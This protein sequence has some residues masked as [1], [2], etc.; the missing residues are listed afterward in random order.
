MSKIQFLPCPVLDALCF[1]EKSRFGNPDIPSH[2]KVAQLAE[3]K[4][5]NAQLSPEFPNDHLSMS[6]L[7]LIVTTAADTPPET[8]T[9]DDLIELFRHPEE[10][11]RTVKSRIPGGFLSTFVYPLLD[12]LVDGHAAIYV[13]KLEEL[14]GIG[15]DV[16][17]RERILPLVEEEIQRN[18]ARM[19]GFDTE[20]LFAHIA[21]LRG[22]SEIPASKI[23]VSLFS[24]P[25]AFSLYGGAFLTCFD[26][27]DQFSLAAHELMHGFA[28]EELTALYLQYTDSD[29]YLQRM[30]NHLIRDQ[31]SG[32]EEEFVVAAQHYL[33]LLSGRYDRRELMREV[34]NFYGGCCPTA[35]VVFD[36]LSREKEVP[37]DYKTWL[38]AQITGG[39]LRRSAL[40]NTPKN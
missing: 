6:A 40:R 14:R 15:F 19:E 10:L 18:R 29:P 8:W 5:F 20:A 21:R 1:M 33:C 32:D 22:E 16:Q 27:P 7:S 28:D 37:S 23:Y 11:A 26:V 31:G 17:Y 12:R 9:L 39:K 34:K 38:K 2:V 30:H 4:T 35:A 13:S 25:T 24:Y 36:L 3:I